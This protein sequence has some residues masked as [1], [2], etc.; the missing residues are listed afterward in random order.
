M[1]RTALNTGMVVLLSH[2]RAVDGRIDLLIPSF[3]RLVVLAGLCWAMGSWV[4][5]HAWVVA[6]VPPVLLRLVVPGVVVVV[7]DAIA[8]VVGLLV[9]IGDALGARAGS[10]LGRLVLIDLLLVKVLTFMADKEWLLE[11]IGRVDGTVTLMRKMVVIVLLVP[12][13]CV[14][15]RQLVLLFVFFRGLVLLTFSFSLI[16]VFQILKLAPFAIFALQLRVFFFIIDVV[17]S[18]RLREVM[19]QHHSAVVIHRGRAHRRG[20]LRAIGI[21]VRSLLL[22]AVVVWV[23]RHLVR[24]R[25]GHATVV[26]IGAHVR[27]VRSHHAS[28]WRRMRPV[29]VSEVLQMMSLVGL[30]SSRVHEHAWLVVRAETLIAAWVARLSRWRCAPAPRATTMAIL[31]ALRRLRFALSDVFHAAILEMLTAVLGS[32]V[33]RW[34][35]LLDLVVVSDRVDVESFGARLLLGLREVAVLVFVCGLAGHHGLLHA[36]VHWRIARLEAAGS[37]VRF[38][39]VRL[40]E[41]LIDEVDV[42]CSHSCGAIRLLL[43]VPVLIGAMIHLASHVALSLLLSLDAAA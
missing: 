40:L 8:N 9:V 42:G 11:E 25:S 23:H 3:C 2:F 31:G 14:T 1:W 43:L 4:S 38:M 7:H 37:P 21:A 10:F 18:H 36:G 30:V 34:L 33:S 16:L 39:S 19:W 41:R 15:A 17:F 6:H 13:C 22:A 27:H 5:V 29:D 26:H 35:P 12:A 20:H 32:L 24:V 28:K